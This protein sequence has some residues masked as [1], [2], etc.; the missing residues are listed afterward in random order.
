MSDVS[1][2]TGSGG[3][4]PALPKKT[5]DTTAKTDFKETLKKVDGHKY[6]KIVSGERKGQYVNQSGNARD[7]D[8]FR[9]VQR[10]GHE[11]HIY[12]DRVVRLPGK[13]S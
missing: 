3:A 4:T 10:N 1:A 5:A 11:F 7:G 12:G 6:A 9:L 13:P 8:A 2:V